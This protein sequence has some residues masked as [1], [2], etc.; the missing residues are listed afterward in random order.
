MALASLSISLQHRLM[1]SQLDMS[2]ASSKDL[3][4]PQLISSFI[5]I[6]F[7]VPPVLI[8]WRIPKLTCGHVDKLLCIRQGLNNFGEMGYGI[9]LDWMDN[10]L[11]TDELAFH[12][13]ICGK[14]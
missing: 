5:I 13:F 1:H 12:L 6:F 3:L 11:Y 9:N 10:T 4:P 7:L 2:T 8:N 14:K